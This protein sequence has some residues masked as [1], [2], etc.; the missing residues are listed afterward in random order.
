MKRSGTSFPLVSVAGLILAACSGGEPE[1]GLPGVLDN[2]RE[3][4]AAVTTSAEADTVVQA[5]ATA[6]AVVEELPVPDSSMFD[7]SNRIVNLWVGPDGSVRDVDVWARR[8][9]DSGPVLVAAGV[10]FGEFSEYFGTPRGHDLAI[11]A[12]GAGPDGAEL[13]SIFE[14]VGDEQLTVVFTNRDRAAVDTLTFWER[15]GEQAPAPPAA[16]SGLV[17]VAAVNTRAFGDELLSQVGSDSFSVGDGSAECPMQRLEDEGFE[18]KVLGGG[19]RVEL[20]LSP[21]PATISIHPWFP[22]AGCEQPS[23]HELTVDVVAGEVTFVF[24]FTRA[25][26]GLESLVVPVR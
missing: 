12:S 4:I 2:A 24:V 16:G 6:P 22:T 14:A 1:Q 15:G 10:G 3:Q 17:V 9:F 25:G 7:G 26:V 8:T 13:G 18:P 21:G 20:E 23:V 11:V 19:Q 5:D